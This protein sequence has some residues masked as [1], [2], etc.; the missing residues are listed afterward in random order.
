[1]I[2]KATEADIPR[3][4]EIVVYGWRTAY[5]G[6]IPDN[7]LFNQRTVSKAMEIRNIWM[8]GMPILFA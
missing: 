4:A 8:P 2:R 6:I 5:R 1:M 7:V 3:L